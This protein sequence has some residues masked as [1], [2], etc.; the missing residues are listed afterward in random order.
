MVVDR[1]G[2]D[3]SPGLVVGVA[4]TAGQNAAHLLVA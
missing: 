1:D 4:A 2:T 3:G